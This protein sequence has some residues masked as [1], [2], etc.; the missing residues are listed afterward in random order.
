MAARV[1]LSQGLRQLAISPIAFTMPS[2]Y[3][4]NLPVLLKAGGN[5]SFARSFSE[6]NDEVAS[7]PNP[8]SDPSLVVDQKDASKMRN[9]VI[10]VEISM[11]YLKS[12][13][14]LTTYGSEPVWVKY[15]RNFKGQFAPETRKTCIRQEKLSTG[16]PCPICRDEYLILDYRN[17]ELLKQFIS[18]F[19]GAILPTLKTGLCQTKQRELLVA[20]TKAKNYGLIAFDV[21]IREYDYS[22]YRS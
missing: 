11:K 19:N 22:D 7:E 18:P 21:P 15:R 3:T 14:Y 5:L 13:G 16:N 8:E 4:T 9:R 10:P 1:I 6:P 17:V 20:I 12:K 2:K